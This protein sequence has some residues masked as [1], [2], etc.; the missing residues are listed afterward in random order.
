[1]TAG[2][3]HAQTGTDPVFRYADPAGPTLSPKAALAFGASALVPGAGQAMNRQWW[4]T[5]LYV[6][7]EAAAIGF[8][9]H[10]DAR[11]DL[12]QRRYNRHGNANWSVVSYAG[13]VHGY[14]MGGARRPNAPDVPITDLLT[15]AGLA[16]FNETGQFPTPAFDTSVDWALID[17]QA[18]R[19]L[20]RNT[21]YANGNAFSHDLPD[22]GSQQ[23]Y[24]LI[25]KYFQ[26]GPGW[27]DWDPALHSVNADKSGMPALWVEHARRNREFNDDFKLSRQM[28][29]LVLVNHVIS[30]FD[31][32]FTVNIRENR[33]ETGGVMTPAG[34]T[35]V[36]RYSF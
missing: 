28:V 17:L 11:G 32:L 36:L 26:F 34:G 4:K 35:V 7:A 31:A 14:Y 9:L 24:E 29:T 13:F 19:A 2:G 33:L 10:Y 30:A 27:R 8:Y 25:G 12:G 1:M 6:G 3:V 5:A 20:E 23:Y 22:Y 18:L 21:L 15:P 16:V